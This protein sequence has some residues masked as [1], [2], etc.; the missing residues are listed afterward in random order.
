[1]VNPSNRNIS[2]APLPLTVTMPRDSPRL[3]WAI[4]SHAVLLSV[5]APG[6]PW[7]SIRAAV[8]DFGYSPGGE[9]ELEALIRAE[10]SR[11]ADLG[12]THL[13]HEFEFVL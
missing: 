1:M 2:I 9:D 6:T 5:T 13:D 11:L 8:L 10:C 7:L 12:M 4:C 3:Q